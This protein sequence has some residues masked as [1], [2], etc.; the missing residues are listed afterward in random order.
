M[1]MITLLSAG[2]LIGLVVGVVIC[3]ILYKVRL[4][5]RSR[6]ILDEARAEAE[7]IKRDKMLEVKEKFI[8]MKADLE[9]QMAVRS[10]KVQSAEAKA[11]QRE[12]QLNQQQQELQRKKTEVEAIR[13]SL[14]SQ[15]EVV[16]KKKTEL[17]RLHK[18]ESIHYMARNDGSTQPG[19]RV[20]HRQPGKKLGS[21]VRSGNG[22]DEIIRTNGQH[23][24]AQAVGDGTKVQRPQPQRSRPNQRG[25]D[26]SGK[27][28]GSRHEHR[29]VVSRT[30]YPA[31]AWNC[32]KNWEKAQQRKKNADIARACSVCQCI[33][34]CEHPQRHEG[35]V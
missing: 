12:M 8:S 26:G 2:A 25:N 24:G 3:L 21:R 6:S 33:Q 31:T 11:R 29:L 27:K 35:T 9:K 22:A 14:T 16:E 34:T 18:A 17:E 13:T 15:V 32:K 20:S 4:N 10:A 23:H 28:A 19:S 5:A 7:T 30:I 1:E